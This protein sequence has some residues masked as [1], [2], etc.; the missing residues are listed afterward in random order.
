MP[1][2]YN[3]VFTTN[4]TIG[5]FDVELVIDRL[6]MTVV[7]NITRN[8]GAENDEIGNLEIM[9]YRKSW[10]IEYYH[11]SYAKP[12]DY[13]DVLK[14]VDAF[15][16]NQDV[17]NDFKKV[18]DFITKH[19]NL[20]K[21]GEFVGTDKA[22]LNFHPEV[23][24]DNLASGILIPRYQ[25]DLY[26]TLADKNNDRFVR[27]YMLADSMGWVTGVIYSVS[28]PHSGNRISAFVG[29]NNLTNK[30]QVFYLDACDIMRAVVQD[31]LTDAEVNFVKVMEEYRALNAK[32]LGT[33]FRLRFDS[34][35]FDHCFDE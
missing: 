29:H 28:S 5:P 4:E 1:I 20:V 19:P 6:K 3:E 8:D 7:A 21:D 13:D 30:L 35:I 9:D 23:S 26:E 27:S 16:Q 17:D 15:V 14:Q 10:D 22:W 2:L 11:L 24:Q 31:E 32:A 12:E 25:K 33:I 18:F 34:D